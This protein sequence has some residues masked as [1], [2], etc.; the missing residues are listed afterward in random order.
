MEPRIVIHLDH[1]KTV[2]DPGEILSGKVIITPADCV[3]VI[4]AI[5][6]SILWYTDGKGDQDLHVHHFRRWSQEGDSLVPISSPLCFQTI[7]PQTPLSYDGLI[8]RVRWCVRVRVFPVKGREI[9][10]EIIFRLGHVAP[11]KVRIQ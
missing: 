4:K 6:L 9:V 10:E 1:R 7:L 3:D 11:A 5:E 2:Y 8:I